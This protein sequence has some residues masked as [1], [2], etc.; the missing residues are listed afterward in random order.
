[1]KPLINQAISDFKD[2][3]VTVYFGV[4]GGACA[5][6][7]E[8]VVNNNCKYVPVLNE[9]AAG[10]AAH[11]YFLTHGMPAGIILTTGPGVT[12]SV[13]GIASCYYDSVPL[14]VLMGQVK[15]S[16]NLAN[17]FSTKMYGF[18]ELPHIE[19]V[20]PVSDVAL[21]FYSEAHYEAQRDAIF[22][23]LQDRN[24]VISIEIQ[25]DVQRIDAGKMR[26]IN[27]ITKSR[28]KELSDKKNKVEIS[29]DLLI[30]GAGCRDSLSE[31]DIENINLSKVPV[32]LS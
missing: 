12:N 3:G 5:R 11:G 10:Y 22:F 14:L 32:V 2:A 15:A 13:S 8:E 30:L 31:S 4:Q 7:I 1:M 27:P 23:A 9:Q 28:N 16:T 24:K 21:S 29:S 26:N 18:Q 19:L 6:I 20:K 17:I 25:D